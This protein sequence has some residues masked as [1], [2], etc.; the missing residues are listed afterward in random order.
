MSKRKKIGIFIIILAVAALAVSLFLFWQ[1]QQNWTIRFH[2][3]LDAFFGEGNW[4]YLSEETKK[5]R[6]YTV[7]N[8][9]STPYTNDREEPGKYHNWNICFKNRNGEEELWTITDHAMKINHSK[10]SFFS[11]E[12]F[13]AKQAF[14]REL[15]EVSFAVSEDDIYQ[16]LLL[17]QLP[18]KEA[19]CLAV[20]ISWRGGNPPLDIYDKLAKEPWFTAN[21]VSVSDYLTSDLYDFY[22]WIHAHD[23][24]VDKLT[25]A[26]RQHLMGSLGTIET[27]LRNTYG[28][29]ADYEI[30]LD[31]AHTAADTA[32]NE[33]T[34]G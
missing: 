17:K 20:D 5:S 3:E 8:Y 14:I 25:A 33:S 12:R 32:G 15:M 1:R 24:K 23:Y 19:A 11:S 22:L 2:S 9:T 28:E 10:N 21:R 29:H 31:A 4:E 18:E 26:E 16:T 7:R 30:Y 27:A 34:G 6:I 13:S